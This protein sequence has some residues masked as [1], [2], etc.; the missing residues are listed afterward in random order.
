MPHS[1][2]FFFY[3][4]DDISVPRV[5]KTK[6][7][8]GIS[9]TNEMQSVPLRTVRPDRHQELCIVYTDQQIRSYNFYS[10]KDDNCDYKITMLLLLLLLLL[11]AAVADDDDSATGVHSTLL[12]YLYDT[13]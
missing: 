1:L 13:T 12:S 11:L 10:E 8:F 7:F 5:I 6:T 4:C 3:F 9:R 2:Q